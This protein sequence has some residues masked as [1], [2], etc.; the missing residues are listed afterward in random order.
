MVLCLLLSLVVINRV[1]VL[2]VL[3]G[4][5]WN[6]GIASAKACLDHRNLYATHE[7]TGRAGTVVNHNG[8]RLTVMIHLLGLGS[9]VR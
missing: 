5:G 7:V 3:E 4:V 8:A 2:V 6:K 9:V 1:I